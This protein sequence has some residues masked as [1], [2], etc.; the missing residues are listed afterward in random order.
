MKLLLVEGYFEGDTDG[1]R[2]IH[3][4]VNKI[5]GIERKFP[6]GYYNEMK[7]QVLIYL[8]DKTL[9]AHEDFKKLCDTLE[10][11]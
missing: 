5:I 2:C 8:G 6:V 9:V 7:D 11:Y 10:R 3:I 4:P 1:V